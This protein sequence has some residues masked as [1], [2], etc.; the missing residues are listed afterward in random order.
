MSWQ[1]R[2]HCELVSLR[3]IINRFL[4]PKYTLENVC[5]QRE[6]ASH[7]NAVTR[8]AIY[9]LKFSTEKSTVNT[10]TDS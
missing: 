10:N 1:Q 5:G 3:I 2:R 7:C 4:F 9:N 6:I 8:K